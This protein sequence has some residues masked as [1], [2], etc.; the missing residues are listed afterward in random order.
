M[1]RSISRAFHY[2]L[3][4]GL[5]LNLALIIPGKNGQEPAGSKSHNAS[6]PHLAGLGSLPR[7]AQPSISSALGRDTASYHARPA[8]DGFDAYNSH[9]KLTTH[10]SSDGVE[11]VSGDARWKWSFVGYGYGDSLRVRNRVA[12]QAAANRVEYR[13]GSL[14]EWYVNGP[15]GLE[16]GFTIT[17]PPGKGNGQPL[18]VELSLSGNLIGA[19]GENRK[20]LSLA[21]ADG[22]QELRYAQLTVRDATSKELSAWLELRGDRLQLRVADDGARYPIVIDPWIQQAKL[23]AS[24]GQADDFFGSATFIAGN[25]VLVGAPN[26]T[27]G[28]NAGQGA[29]YI[30]VKPT[31]GWATTSHFTA[32]LTASN[33]LSGDNFG[34]AVSITSTAAVIGACSQGGACSNGP[35]KAYVY[36]KPAAGWATTSTFTA[37]LTASDGLAADAFGDSVTIAG[38]TVMVGAPNAT[39]EGHANQGAV[40]VFV[41]SSHGWRN[42]TETAK[43]T[44][45]D[46]LGGDTL[47]FVSLNGNASIALLGASGATLGGNANQ[48]AA[49]VFI[50]PTTGWATSS[51]FAAKLTVSDGASGDF[52]GFCNFGGGCVSSSGKTIIV[53]A[54]QGGSS[55]ATGPGKAY[56]F[57]EPTAGWKTTSAFTAELTAA[58]GLTGDNFGFSAAISGTGTMAVVG[59]EFANTRQ[60]AAYVFIMPGKGWA[61]TSTFS[62][63]LTASD[64]K[65]FS[66]FSF[67]GAAISGTTIAVG[68]AGTKVGSNNDQGAAY[69]FGDPVAAVSVDGAETEEGVQK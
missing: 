20:D 53:A 13:H 10:F 41:K 24:D 50:K 8:A 22:S 11:A 52:F 32:K 33:G 46:G 62:A 1:T 60:G 25:T 4:L 37:E 48:G 61:T 21:R 68:A 69:I 35:G 19:V 23:T 5:V 27:I 58:G 14:T 56:I 34:G 36:V 47:G 2:L 66:F 12:P 6:S 63:K 26:A 16:Q 43:L 55:S 38:T 30:F 29:A 57:L 54:P 9:E 31:A 15:V 51:A 42:M 65:P 45:S 49:Y 18:T 28:S 67:G 3:L 64:G 39:V 7:S 40:Y 17:R 59:A 44:A